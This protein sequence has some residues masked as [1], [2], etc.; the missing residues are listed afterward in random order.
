MGINGNKATVASV[1]GGE[2][3]MSW[4]NGGTVGR[5]VGIDAFGIGADSPILTIRTVDALNFVGLLR[6]GGNFRIVSITAG[7]GT[8]VADGGAIATPAG[9]RWE[10]QAVGS[11]IN[12]YRNGVL[13]ATGTNSAHAATTNYGIG[14]TNG[15]VEMDNFSVE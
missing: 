12:A 10:L 15:A 5:R 7:A 9:E 1:P 4:V 3:A 14:G 2:W 6:D 8:V 11:T 13:L